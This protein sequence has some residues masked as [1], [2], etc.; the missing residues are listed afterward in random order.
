M[1]QQGSRHVSKG[2]VNG[3]RSVRSLIRARSSATQGDLQ[4]IGSRGLY[5]FYLRKLHLLL[6][7]KSLMHLHA[8]LEGFVD[9]LL[10]VEVLVGLEERVTLQVDRLLQRS[11][12]QSTHSLLRRAQG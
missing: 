8:P 3:R 10:H 2:L 7:Q 5:V 6:K 1:M 12:G 9:T 11:L 4:L